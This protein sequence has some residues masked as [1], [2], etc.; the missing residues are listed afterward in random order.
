MLACSAFWIATAWP[1]GA[2]AVG[3]VAVICSLFATFDDPTPV[4]STFTIGVIASVPLAGI[5]QFGILPALDGYTQLVLSLAPILIPIGVLMAIPRYTL[6]GLPLAVGL[7]LNLALQSSYT[8]D[9]ASFLNTAT[10]VVF[11][12]LTGLAVTKLM[13]AVGAEAGARRLLRAGWRDLAAL[14]DRTF[15]PTRAE[16]ASR[17]LDRVG[18]LMPRLSRAGR[19]PELE[20]ADALR[21]LRTGVNVIGLQEIARSLNERARDAMTRVL[22]GIAGYFR[23]LARGRHHMPA[24]A[25]LGYIE[26]LIG[27]ILV[28]KSPFVRHKGLAAAVALRR[29][30]YPDAPPYVG[31]PASP[32][33]V[34]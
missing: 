8:A 29:N 6:V 5:Y 33:D 13:R 3:L 27:N 20:T 34:A 17:M 31:E 12:S 26:G 15:Q 14:A 21:D 24:P 22:D 11:G 7:S 10:A 1:Q 30:L 32:S 18:L 25:L 9:M 19:D 4:M 28:T 23:A 2:A 16:W